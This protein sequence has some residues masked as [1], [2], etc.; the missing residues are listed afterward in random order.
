MNQS[1]LPPNKLALEVAQD[2]NQIKEALKGCHKPQLVDFLINHALRVFEEEVDQSQEQEGLQ[3][4]G[5]SEIAEEMGYTFESVEDRFLLGKFVLNQI[6]ELAEKGQV[7]RDGELRNV[8][9]YPDCQGVRNVISSF[10][11]SE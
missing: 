6:G 9:F 7:F 11:E 3:W 8:L 2:I 1:E 10:F 5:C 4:R